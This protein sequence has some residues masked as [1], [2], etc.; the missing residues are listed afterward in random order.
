MKEIFFSIVLM[1]LC[2]LSLTAEDFTI[3]TLDS[4]WDVGLYNSLAII[5]G[6]PAIAYYDDTNGYLKY[7]AATDEEGMSWGS[8]VIIGG[9][10]ND[11][12]TILG[13]T[14]LEVDGNPAL[15]FCDTTSSATT[16]S[17]VY[18][19]ATNTD[20]TE[21]DA[22]VI[23]DYGGRD[24]SMAT[25]NGQPAISYWRQ[26]AGVR[27]VRASNIT[28]SAWEA[29]ITIQSGD[30]AYTSLAVVNGFPAIG[31]L[32]DYDLTFVRAADSDG[33]TWNTPVTFTSF[34]PLSYPAL[35]VINGNPAIA[36]SV[37][38]LHPALKY[39]RATN[40]NGTNWG[41]AVTVVSDSGYGLRARS[42]TVVGR[43]ACI[44]GATTTGLSLVC[45]TDVNG[46]IWDS[47]MLA[48]STGQS[49]S[50]ANVAA[51]AAIS[52]YDMTN[53]DLKYAVSNLIFKDGFETSDTSIWSSE[54][55]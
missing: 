39:M 13:L 18:V 24:L 32:R 40:V 42:M 49:S 51:Y 10:D 15:A 9:V 1:V 23:L 29:P 54:G 38:G 8:P 26:G 6:C 53:G 11:G 45:S 36:F 22:E 27:F 4:E 7:I 34:A 46:N 31:Y 48:D 28:G 52:Y 50:L 44:E 14:L 25:V 16:P 20:G 47:P 2:T 3:T 37:G 33:T 35:A 30:V 17:L 41:T 55:P 5:D 19:R 12:R 43:K 21:W